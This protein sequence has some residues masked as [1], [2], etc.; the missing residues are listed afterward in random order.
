VAAR[1]R[2]APGISVCP[3][4]DRDC[5]AP[6]FPR[7]RL[8]CRVPKSKDDILK[9]IDLDKARF[10]GCAGEAARPRNDSRLLAS[11]VDRPTRCPR[12][13]IGWNAAYASRAAFAGANEPLC[14]AFY[15]AATCS[16]LKTVGRDILGLIPSCCKCSV[17]LSELV[18]TR[19]ASSGPGDCGHH[20]ASI[21]ETTLDRCR[22]ASLRG[23]CRQAGRGAVASDGKTI[24]SPALN[25]SLGRGAYSLDLTK[26]Y[27]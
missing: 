14:H 1:T 26:A 24:L 23:L 21:G 27:N 6:H 16:V 2:P 20:A 19:P 15:R 3:V 7:A 8:R 25:S 9:F 17:C 12:R 5:S 13:E 4:A 11:L 18:D 22:T 10:E